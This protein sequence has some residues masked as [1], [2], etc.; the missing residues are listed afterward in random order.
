[1]FESGLYLINAILSG[2]M[3]Y[4]VYRQGAKELRWMAIG[5]LA[6]TIHQ[7]CLV[8]GVFSALATLPLTLALV[9]TIRTFLYGRQRKS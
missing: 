7:T 2:I 6:I 5:F 9:Y 4:I 3:S 1:M 8:F